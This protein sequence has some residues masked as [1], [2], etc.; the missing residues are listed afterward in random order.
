MAPASKPG[1]CLPSTQP[2]LPDGV[3]GDRER[4]AEVALVCSTPTGWH[5]VVYLPSWQRAGKVSWWALRTFSMS[6]PTSGVS[7]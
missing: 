7:V 4:V 1:R 3:G 2:A 6:S 5:T